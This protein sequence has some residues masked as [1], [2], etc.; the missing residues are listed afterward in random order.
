MPDL[1]FAP[2]PKI[3]IMTRELVAETVSAE[4][5]RFARQSVDESMH[6]LFPGYHYKGY[7]IERSGRLTQ[8]HFSYQHKQSWHARIAAQV[9]EFF[10]HLFAY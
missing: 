5:L 10:R 7:K 1:L 3:I 8:I 9:A 4:E 6:N 2:E